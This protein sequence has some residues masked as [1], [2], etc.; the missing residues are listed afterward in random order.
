LFTLCRTTFMTLTCP[1]IIVIIRILNTMLLWI[2]WCICTIYLIFLH[3][4]IKVNSILLRY[5]CISTRFYNTILFEIVVIFIIRTRKTT[6]YLF[7]N[8]V[9]TVFICFV[10]RFFLTRCHD[11]D[12]IFFNLHFCF[13]TIF[14]FYFKLVGLLLRVENNLF[15]IC[16]CLFHFIIIKIF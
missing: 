10:F 15:I 12:L 14:M 16:T 3:I 4:K 13:I 2:F 6:T 11:L 8:F 7:F 5:W 9:T 1:I